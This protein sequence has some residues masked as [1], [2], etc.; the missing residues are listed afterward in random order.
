M[1]RIPFVNDFVGCITGK[2]TAF[3]DFSKG[4]GEM[5]FGN[6]AIDIFAFMVIN[7][8]ICAYFEQNN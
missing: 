2:F 6:L 1:L 5:V 7:S 8:D 4:G 3:L